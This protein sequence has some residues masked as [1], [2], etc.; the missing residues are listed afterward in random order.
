[1]LKKFEVKNFK[2]FNDWFVF[3]LTDTKSYA[4]N[5][6]CVEDGI[7]KK[8]LIYGPNGCGKTNLG[9]A[10]F[11]IKTHLTDQETNAFYESNYLNADSSAELAE[12]KYTF[13]ICGA[14]VEYRYGKR[15]V[16]EL[17]Y[18]SLLIDGKEVIAID[19]RESSL[20]H[21]DLEGTEN[22]NRELTDKNIS[23]V[24]YV[25]NNSS[26]ESDDLLSL[27]KFASSLDLMYLNPYFNDGGDRSSPELTSRDILTGKNNSKKESLQ[28][29]EKFLNDAGVR[30]KL[31]TIMANDHDILAF[32][33]ENKAVNFF[34]IASAG[35]ISL[36]HLYAD[37]LLHNIYSKKFIE[38]G[39][40]MFLFI[41]EFD[42]FF[43]HAASKFIVNTIRGIDNCQ[44]I[45]TTH[46]TSIMSND[47]LRPDCYF[48]M[49]ESEIKPMHRFTDKELRKAHNIEKMYKAGAFNG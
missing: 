17:V 9:R 30:C 40:S 36:T 18:E 20:I 39:I 31:T 2:N 5:A 4:F 42:A 13:H 15:S 41:D 47:L 16:K 7:V 32:Q 25:N 24:K 26:G 10:L 6:D 27:S 28:S 44:A 19:R 49:S 21:L 14:I 8:A 35:T 23:A 38:L 29:F 46:N 48:I 43:H 34:S 11:E 3:D 12:F 1:M 37:I 45:L 22:F 33:F